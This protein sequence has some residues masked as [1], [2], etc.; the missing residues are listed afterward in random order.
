[1]QQASF[2]NNQDTIEMTTSKLILKTSYNANK[3]D[4]ITLVT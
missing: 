3:C 4:A 1:M 2:M